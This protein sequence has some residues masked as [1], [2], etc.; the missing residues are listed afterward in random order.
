MADAL[1]NSNQKSKIS[2]KCSKFRI[3]STK[4]FKIKFEGFSFCRVLQK[5]HF[6]G[7]DQGFSFPFWLLSNQEGYSQVLYFR[8]C[9]NIASY[10]YLEWPC[11]APLLQLQE[12]EIKSRHPPKRLQYVTIYLDGL[13]STCQFLSENADS[14]QDWR[15]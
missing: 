8:D 9:S 4:K 7:L 1:S 6:L 13:Q 3:R 5:P 11:I 15:K 14:L 2:R 12:L 10:I